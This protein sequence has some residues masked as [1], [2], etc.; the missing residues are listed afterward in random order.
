MTTTTE[1][2]LPLSRSDAILRVMQILCLSESRAVERILLEGIVFMAQRPT[3][4]ERRCRVLQ[5]F[6]SENWL[7]DFHESLAYLQQMGQVQ[8]TAGEYHLTELGSEQLSTLAELSDIDMGN[9]SKQI[10]QLASRVRVGL[11]L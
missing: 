4:A 6:N 3:Y 2:V 9:E 10:H 7:L 1:A 11:G 8:K 5:A